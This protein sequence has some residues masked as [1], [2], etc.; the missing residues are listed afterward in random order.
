MDKSKKLAKEELANISGGGKCSKY[1][2][3]TYNSLGISDYTGGQKG[4]Y[5]PLI[6]TLGNSCPKFSR[7]EDGLAVCNHCFGC[8]KKSG[9]LTCYCN[10]RSKELDPV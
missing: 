6:V 2:S 10:R 7:E 3:E 5:H 4:T 9:T 1:S 8:S